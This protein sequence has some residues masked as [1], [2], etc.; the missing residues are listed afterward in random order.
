[1]G[2]GKAAA[3][4]NMRPLRNHRGLSKL[5]YVYPEMKHSQ[6][7]TV[8]VVG[9]ESQVSAFADFFQSFH[10]GPCFSLKITRSY[11]GVLEFSFLSTPQRKGTGARLHHVN[12]AKNFLNY[13]CLDSGEDNSV[14]HA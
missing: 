1:M 2:S 13:I 3:V 5:H 4:W 10:P 7:H 11:V 8:G 9:G 12:C 14:S 6:L